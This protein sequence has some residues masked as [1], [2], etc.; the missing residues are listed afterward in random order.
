VIDETAALTQTDPTRD[1]HVESYTQVDA[2]V[3]YEFRGGSGLLSAFEGLTVRVGSTNLFDQEPPSAAASW[4]DHNAD[5][6]TYSAI[7]RTL[8]VDVNLKF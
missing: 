3:G 7:G 2:H 5:T 1:Q 4:T 8:Y 6:Q